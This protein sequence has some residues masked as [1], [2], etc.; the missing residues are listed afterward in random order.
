M[1]EKRQTMSGERR[2]DVRLRAADGKERSRTFRTRKEAERYQRSQHTAIDQ[3]LWIDPRS[4]QVTLAT[5]AAEWQRTVVHLRPITRRITTPT[6]ATTSS[7][8]WE[9]SS[10]PS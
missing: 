10:S 9:T 3:G 4:G 1:I 2:Y 7:P 5:W 6:C 8:S